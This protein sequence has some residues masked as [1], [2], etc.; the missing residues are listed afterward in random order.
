MSLPPA[1]P[2]HAATGH[3]S[4]RPLSLVL[5][6]HTLGDP[7]R[8]GTPASWRRLAARLPELLPLASRATACSSATGLKVIPAYRTFTGHQLDQPQDKCVGRRPGMSVGSAQ[9]PSG[10]PGRHAG[11]AASPTPDPDDIFCVPIQLRFCGRNATAESGCEGNP[12]ARLRTFSFFPSWCGCERI[13]ESAG[14]KTHNETHNSAGSQ[15][16]SQFGKND[17][18]WSGYF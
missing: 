7:E 3:T 11:R 12:R 1:I 10:T 5:T 13:P 17:K 8:P 9:C 16:G 18:T 2:R 6:E 4:A 15:Q 14:W